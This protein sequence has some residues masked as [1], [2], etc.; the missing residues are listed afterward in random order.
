MPLADSCSK[1]RGLVSISDQITHRALSTV[2]P[3]PENDGV[4][5]PVDTTT[6][7]FKLQLALIQ[8]N[9]IT[10]PLILTIDGY[11]ISGHRRYA[12]AQELE[13]ETVPCRTA[14][15]Y[16]NDPRFL[17]LLAACNAQRTKSIDEILRE[18][19]ILVDPEESHRR[20]REHRRK[21][22]KVDVDMI[23][24]GEAKRR[25]RITPAKRPFFDAIL[26]IIDQYQDIWPLSVRQIHYFLL[27]DPPL[28]HARKPQSRYW[29]DRKCY[30]AADELTVLGRLSGEIPVDAIDDPTRTVVVWDVYREMGTFVNEQLNGFMKGGYRDLMQTQPNHIEIIGEK[31]T[32]EG[33]IR[34]VAADYTIPYSI[35]RGYS[36]LPPRIKMAR[37]FKR[38]GKEKL[39]LLVLS[40]FDPEGEDIG[41]AF[42]QSMRDDF[43]IE[44]IVPVKVALTKDQVDAL[45]LPPNRA[46]RKKKGSRKKKFV[47]QY[48]EAAYELEALPPATLQQYLRN[49]IDKVLDIKAYNIEVSLEKRDAAQSETIRKVAIERIGEINL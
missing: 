8:E 9:G 43:G 38:S 20:L 25:R 40:D 27:N 24:L 1:K 5:K 11:I 19:V 15:I 48:G 33:V 37:R 41:R 16:H 13:L 26:K 21:R 22:A 28:M 31:N 47:R 14:D 39:I 7:D 3:A 29:N 30:K 45:H 18:Q 6:T 44:N 36:S 12:A 23:A 35:G 17:P 46:T 34:P 32:I 10:D 49:A 42:A 2:R 4:Y